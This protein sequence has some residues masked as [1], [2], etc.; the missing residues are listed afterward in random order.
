MA[1]EYGGKIV[2]EWADGR[3]REIGKVEIDTEKLGA[4]CR[5]SL[6]RVRLG[7]EFIMTG[8]RIWKRGIVHERPGTD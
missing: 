2:L 8:L 3:E 6:R 4:E 7:W 5:L 1:K